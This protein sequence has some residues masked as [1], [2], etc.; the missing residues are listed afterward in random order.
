MWLCEVLM[1]WQQTDYKTME[2]QGAFLRHIKSETTTKP[3]FPLSISNSGFYGWLSKPYTV[4]FAIGKSKFD[5][6]F[7]PSKTPLLLSLYS[8]AISPFEIDWLIDWDISQPP[9][10]RKERRKARKKV[11]MEG[12]TVPYRPT[13][14][15]TDRHWSNKVLDGRILGVSCYQFCIKINWTCITISSIEVYIL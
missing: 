10:V 7:S 4:T 1:S 13:D 11:R 14:G 5:V 9:A 2:M 3:N 6:F 8:T 15:R 12:R